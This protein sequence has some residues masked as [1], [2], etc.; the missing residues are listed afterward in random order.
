VP[1]VVGARGVA[2]DVR[3]HS[4]N[5]DDTFIAVAPGR[6]ADR[7]L[8]TT[9]HHGFATGLIA[10]ALLLDGCASASDQ[11][12]AQ[13]AEQPASRETAA[14]P[15]SNEAPQ[16]VSFGYTIIYVSDVA[17]S[18]DFWE[19]AFGLRRRFVHESGQYAELDTGSTALAFVSTEMARSNFPE[20]FSYTDN[21]PS[22]PPAGIEVALTARDVQATYD[23]AVAA[24]ATS[25]VAPVVRPWG[26]TVAYVRDLDG[27]LVE[28][29]SP[30][31]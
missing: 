18:V 13:N 11:C 30:A 26:Q 28:I 17:R 10:L 9:S 4:T 2:Y 15:T 23:R 6:E 8:T 5:Y 29:A 19:R 3:V 1:R 21:D 12:P 22:R 27:V 24:G 14:P 16:D 25:V 20:G 7:A 31:H